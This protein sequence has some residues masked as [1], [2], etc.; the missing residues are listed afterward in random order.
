MLVQYLMQNSKKDL[1]PFKHGVHLCK[2]QR[3]KT[4]QEV[5]DMRHIPYASVVG[6]LVYVMLCTRPDICYVVGIVSRFH[7][8]PNFNSSRQGRGSDAQIEPTTTCKYR[9]G[10]LT[11]KGEVGLH[12]KL[13]QTEMRAA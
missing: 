4:P 7:P 1:L 11:M 3:P 8:Y 9:S 10:R 13:E 5:E 2:E 6:S 12:L